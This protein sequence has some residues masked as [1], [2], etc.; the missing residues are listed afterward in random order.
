MTLQNQIRREATD[1]G[2]TWPAVQA[3][4]C[5]IKEAEK[6]RREQPN[7]VREAA[8]C[9]ATASTPAS[10]PFW[11]HGFSSRWGARVE[12]HDYTAVP[13]YDEIGQQIATWFPEYATDDGTERLFDFLLSPYDKL[14]TRE[15]IYQKAISRLEWQEPDK[16]VEL[17][18]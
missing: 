10:W 4:Y 15:E 1:R 16:P 11:R 6:A 5:E 8:W 3:A 13:G 7:A 12:R 17:E 2:L 18:F 9:M 14:P